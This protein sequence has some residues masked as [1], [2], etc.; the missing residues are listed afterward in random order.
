MRAEAG[1][2]REGNVL[3]RR[4]SRR[5]VSSASTAAISV[6]LPARG[7]GVE[8]GEEAGERR[9]VAQVRRARP[10]QLGR[11]LGGLDQRDRVGADVRLCRRPLSE[12]L[13]QLGR[14]GGGVESA[15]CPPPKVLAESGDVSGQAGRHLDAASDSSSSRTLFESL[16]P[17]R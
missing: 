15:A 4:V 5:K 2:R 14:R 7:L 9:G 16:R 10:R 6:S 1:D 11:V 8:P 17:S 12:P 3:Q 13:G